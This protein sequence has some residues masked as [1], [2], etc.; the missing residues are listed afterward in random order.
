MRL[1]EAM[2]PGGLLTAGR[3]D[4]P[5]SLVVLLPDG[6]L[7]LCACYRV[8]TCS[9]GFRIPAIARPPAPDVWQMFV[10]VRN[11]L[12]LE[13]ATAESAFSVLPGRDSMAR[14][15]EITSALTPAGEI[16]LAPALRNLPSGSYTYTVRRADATGEQRVLDG[17]GAAPRRL[18]WV[19]PQGMARVP[20][21][22]IGAYRIQVTD[23][24][25]VMRLD[26]FA[27]AA[28]AGAAAAESARLDAARQTLVQWTR[29][30]V[31][32]PRHDF[33]RVYLEARASALQAESQQSSVESGRPGETP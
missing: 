14:L 17:A 5:H 20:V 23:E 13:P 6:Q 19:A 3:S 26:I 18:L 15:S 31:G 32:W 11:E 16:S 30:S 21:G 27:L 4:S 10:E 33:L 9:Q 7:L 12:L 24:A 2:P 29:V 1:G 22:K 25:H 8:Q 28:P